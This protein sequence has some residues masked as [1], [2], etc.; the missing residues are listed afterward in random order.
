MTDTLTGAWIAPATPKATADDLAAIRGTV[1][2]Y[3][4]GWYDA[5][6]ERISQALHPALSK[7]SYR[8]DPGRTPALSSLTADQM[9]AW[10]AAGEGRA[11]GHVERALDIR[12]VDVAGSIAS[13]VVRSYDYVEYLHLVL[14]SDGWRIVNALWRW[15]DGRGPDA[16]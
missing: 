3:F 5:D 1:H 13:V 9:V 4:E 14:T 11:S 6:P 8:Q 16:D 10:A 7:R 2:D 15:A 12:V